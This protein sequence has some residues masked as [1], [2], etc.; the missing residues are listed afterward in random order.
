MAEQHRRTGLA[1]R[2]PSANQPATAKFVGTSTVPSGARPSRRGGV[3]TH[4]AG[5]RSRTGGGTAG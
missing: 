1:G 2:G 3:S 4:T 5:I